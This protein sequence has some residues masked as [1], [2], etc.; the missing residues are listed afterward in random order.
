MS[1]CPNPGAG[2]NGGGSGSIGG[3]S[4]GADLDWGDEWWINDTGDNTLKGVEGDDC[5]PPRLPDCMI[6]DLLRTIPEARESFNRLYPKMLPAERVRL[7]EITQGIVTYVVD[8][9]K[10]IEDNFQHE[11][12]TP[13]V[14]TK[15]PKGG[16]G[17][18]GGGGNGTAGARPPPR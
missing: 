12:N 18:L 13:G 11:Q 6:Y 2:W 9:P 8:D 17:G 16:M 4:I 7:D 10:F 14:Q 3:C 15:G 5:N 1:S